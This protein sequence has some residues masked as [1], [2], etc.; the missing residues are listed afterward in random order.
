MGAEATGDSVED[1]A[2]NDVEEAMVK[3]AFVLS[4]PTGVPEVGSCGRPHAAPAFPT[5]LP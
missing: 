5:L 1:S 2:S 3:G 4:A